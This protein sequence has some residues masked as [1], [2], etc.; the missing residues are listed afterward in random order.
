MED[1]ISAL[2]SN[3]LVK[4]KKVVHAFMA[5][6]TADLKA[7]RR[8]QIAASVMIEGEEPEEKD[9]DEDEDDESKEKGKKP[10]EDDDESDDSDDSDEDE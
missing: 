6:S 3:D 7:K 9:D 5:E 8:I 4:A 10:S 1:F 2:K